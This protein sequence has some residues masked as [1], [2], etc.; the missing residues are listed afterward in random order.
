MCEKFRLYADHFFNLG[1]NVVCISNERNKYN[2]LENNLLKSPNHEWKHLINQRQSVD[3]LNSYNWENATGIGI[4]LGFDN[5]FAID[6]DGAIDF[7]IV[8]AICNKLNIPFNYSWIMKSGS[9][10]GYHIILKHENKDSPKIKNI[11]KIDEI[12]INDIDAFYPKSYSEDSYSIDLTNEEKEILGQDSDSEFFKKPVIYQGEFINAIYQYKDY[13]Y[14]M[15]EPSKKHEYMFSE[16]LNKLSITGRSVLQ[17][18]QAFSKIEFIW[19]G[20]I[21]LP[22][23]LHE[24]GQHYVFK[25][26][27]PL[28]YPKNIDFFKI[29]SLCNLICKNKAIKSIESNPDNNPINNYN[30]DKYNILVL[31]IE[32][33]TNNSNSIE[34]GLIQL[35][36]LIIDENGNQIKKRNLIL[37]RNDI[38]LDPLHSKLHG[39]SSFEMELLG[40]DPVDAF[41]QFIEELKFVGSVLLYNLE[42]DVKFICDEAK[43]FGVNIDNVI[44]KQIIDLNEIFSNIINGINTFDNFKY[45]TQKSVKISL[46]ELYYLIY[47]KR[48]FNFSNAFYKSVLLLHCYLRLSSCRTEFFMQEIIKKYKSE[49]ESN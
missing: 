7:D 12:G 39:I 36:W 29:K 42:N 9:G 24:T 17:I 47:N 38:Y 3:E 32:K 25:N 5:L 22:P 15:D 6:I 41:Y 30:I 26:K 11:Q 4:V 19:K 13:N 44:D 40:V 14:E 46:P 45:K 43:K 34:T 20:I 49:F 2:L 31:G 23:S 48:I 18:K 33:N 21:I 28:Y 1:L 16:S 8:L 10:C 37:K 35:S 27:I